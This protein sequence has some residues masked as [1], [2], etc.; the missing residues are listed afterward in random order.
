MKTITATAAKNRISD[1]WN[2]AKEEPVTVL[3]RGERIA[4]IMSPEEYDRITSARRP[5]R[6][7]YLK[8]LFVG[9]DWDEVLARP[10][11]GFEEYL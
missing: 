7:G 8:G 6:G 1:A 9:V 5:R 11:P 10:V 3:S 2:M 4:I